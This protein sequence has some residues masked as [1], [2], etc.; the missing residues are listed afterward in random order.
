MRTLHR[1]AHESDGEV[2]SEG[3]WAISYGDM[4][5]LLLAFFILFF[6]VDPQRDRAAKMHAAVLLALDTKAKNLHLDRGH[7]D[8]IRAGEERQVGIDEQFLK[9]LHGVPH[10]I[11]NKI[12][13]EFPDISFYRT[14]EV[15]LTKDGDQALARF[16]KAF[17]PFVGS[18]TIGIRAYTDRRGVKQIANRPFRDNLELSALRSIAT[19]RSLQRSGIPI[20]Q[21]TL[22]G[23]GELSAT[24]EEIRRLPSSSKLNELDLARKVVLVLQMP[25]RDG[26]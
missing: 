19:M 12:L 21:I 16:A 10:Q 17:M 24:A 15:K 22:G 7:D 3:S 5:T 2:D 26:L 25:G 14:A 23:Y 20:S 11:G 18:Y 1:V 4:V 13:V 8:Q 9:R 6:T